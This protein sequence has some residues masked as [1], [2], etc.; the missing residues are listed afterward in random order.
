MS[1]RFLFTFMLIYFV[2]NILLMVRRYSFMS[3]FCQ[4]HLFVMPHLFVRASLSFHAYLIFFHGSCFSQ[5]TSFFML[6]LLS[7][8]HLFMHFFFLSHKS[9]FSSVPPF[10]LMAHLFFLAFYFIWYLSFSPCY[11]VF[12]LMLMCLLIS[13]HHFYHICFSLLPYLFPSSFIW[14]NSIFFHDFFFIPPLSW[15][16]ATKLW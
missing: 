3:L 16:N 6:L 5:E 7:A 4:S 8:Q 15:W 2:E 1:F 12:F 10:L 13:I 9:L 11:S 14:L